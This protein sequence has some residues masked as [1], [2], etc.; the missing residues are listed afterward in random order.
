MSPRAAQS[1]SNVRVAA[2]RRSALILANAISIGFG[3][4]RVLREEQEPGA[5][6]LERRCGAGALVDREIVR[7][8]DVAG[9]KGRGQL[10]LDIGV[11]CRAVHGA[12]HH[13]RGGEPI[14]P[15]RSDGD[16]VPQR[17]NS[18]EARGSA[19]RDGCAQRGRVI[20]VLTAVSSM[21]TR[22]AG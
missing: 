22:R 12:I 1:A 17:P 6:R 14:T 13:P 21:N 2:L 8:H 10:G 18:R 3:S 20:F 7:D 4:G 9:P 19:V 11:E 15:E 16:K 5:P